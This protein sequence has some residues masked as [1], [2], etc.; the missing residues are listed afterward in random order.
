MVYVAVVSDLLGDGLLIGAGSAVSS[1]IAMVLAIEQVLA[2]IPEG[3]AVIA[4]FRQK[5]VNRTRRLLLSA[6]FVIP[7][8]G[9]AIIAFFALRG[10]PEILKM[11]ALLF[12]TGL[13]L[14]AAV[15]DMLNE[16]HDS[17]EDSRWS[18]ISFLAGFALFV[19][20][21]GSVG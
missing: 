5:G 19:V 17:A 11:T 15:E 10:Q 3:F 9:A 14:L 12:V 18:A 8:V 4:N 16:A 13:F 6:S 7:V 1:R 20:V 2:D 21:S